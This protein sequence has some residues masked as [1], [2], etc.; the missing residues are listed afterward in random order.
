MRV[1]LSRIAREYRRALVPLGILLAINVALLA[2]VVLPLVQ[3]VSSNDSRAQSAARAE[4]AALAEFQKAEAL[5][6]GR[7]RATT[8]LEMFYKQVLP[9]DVESARRIVQ[10]KPRRLAT[11]HDVHYARAQSDTEDVRESSLERLSSAI[12]LS[13]SWEDIRAFIYELETAPEFI[14]IDNVAITEG[15]D[16]N[17]PLSLSVEVS[18]YY[19][20]RAVRTRTGSDGR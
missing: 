6:E 18:T 2:L 8:D 15:T 16:T 10:S 11:A 9:L 20:G 17:S 1:P 4:S 13:G 12:S 19:R 3:R 7:A 14:V 5:R